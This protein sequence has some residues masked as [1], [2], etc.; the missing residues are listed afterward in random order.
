MSDFR[1]IG[2]K[3]KFCILLA[4][5]AGICISVLAQNNGAYTIQGDVGKAIELWGINPDSLVVTFT[6]DSGEA[7]TLV[8]QNGQFTYS[9]IV[10]SRYPAMGYLLAV[11][12]ADPESSLRIPVF[13]E[14]GEIR[15]RIRDLPE[16]GMIDIVV[17]GTP[18]NDLMSGRTSRYFDLMY[19]MLDIARDTLMDEALRTRLIEEKI[20]AQDSLTRFFY[21]DNRDTPIAPL[22]AIQEFYE[23]NRFLEAGEEL[24]RLS[25]KFPDHPDLHNLESVWM[26]MPGISVGDTIPEAMRELLTEAEALPKGYVFIDFWSSLN[27]RN[28]RD[29][30]ALKKLPHSYNGLPLYLWSISTDKS[31]GPMHRTLGRYKPGGRQHWDKGHILSKAFHIT[32]YPARFLV[33]PNGVVVAKGD[34]TELPVIE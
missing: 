10:H 20:E 28:L 31:P 3:R 33:D 7:D 24:A 22:L 32:S 27:D 8:F 2:M 4:I 14:P 34:F 16:E 18:S 17:S 26:S 5:T 12:D 1:F 15:I 25:K 21:R 29:F 6:P 9:G 13:L 23:T 19:E 30:A 11:T